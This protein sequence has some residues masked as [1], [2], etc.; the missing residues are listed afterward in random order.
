MF[1]KGLRNKGRDMYGG[2]A[3]NNKTKHTKTEENRLY[4][5]RYIMTC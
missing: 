3:N 5:E 1:K 4:S 2:S